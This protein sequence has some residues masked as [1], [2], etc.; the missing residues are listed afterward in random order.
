MW[1][2]MTADEGPGPHHVKPK[3]SHTAT[4]R[5][6]V[7]TAIAES[8]CS[9]ICTTI[10]LDKIGQRDKQTTLPT[11]QNRNC[12]PKVPGQSN[13]TPMVSRTVYRG[14]LSFA[15]DA[16]LLRHGNETTSSTPNQRLRHRR[17]AEAEG[18]RAKHSRFLELHYITF[19][20]DDAFIQSDLQ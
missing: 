20:L 16:P 5:V 11:K 17:Q 7:S 10:S 13:P 8:S 2:P 6:R 4:R 15:L 19:H 3:Y 12:A 9:T 14:C 18:G 1:W